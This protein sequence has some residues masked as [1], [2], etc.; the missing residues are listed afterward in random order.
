MF[1][2]LKKDIR[3]AYQ[4]IAIGAV[5]FLL[6][7]LTNGESGTLTSFLILLI[8]PV[9]ATTQY[10]SYNKTDILFVSLPLDRKM[11][12]IAKYISTFIQLI[13]LTTIF[14]VIS[15]CVKLLKFHNINF[16]EIVDFLP[17]FSIL[18]SVNYGVILPIYF[19]GINYIV[20]LII[21]VLPP[22]VLFMFT[23]LLLFPM[24]G[25]SLMLIPLSILIIVISLF[26]SIF[27]YKRREF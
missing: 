22:I 24:L 9:M 1:I 7:L 6:F 27:I 5:Y 4:L 12:V 8:Y 15:Y 25:S 14:F 11:I 23:K 17:M 19:K 18:C 26:I 20:L 2:L 10:D 21:C 3:Y 16:N 13:I